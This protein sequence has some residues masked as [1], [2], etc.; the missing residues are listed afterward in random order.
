ME[1]GLRDLK[2]SC[3]WQLEDFEKFL[4]LLGVQINKLGWN[5]EKILNVIDLLWKLHESMVICLLLKNSW[6][7]N[8]KLLHL[9]CGA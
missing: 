1:I 6:S 2:M 4:F 3:I 7:D 5:L 8:E 9:K